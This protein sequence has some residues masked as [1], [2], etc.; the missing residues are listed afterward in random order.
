MDNLIYMFLND[1]DN[2]ILNSIDIF[3]NYIHDEIALLDNVLMNIIIS[4]Y[5]LWFNF[6][7]DS[8]QFFPTEENNNNANGLSSDRIK[9]LPEKV[10]EN[11]NDVCTIC[12][13]NYKTQ[14]LVIILPCNHYYH[15]DCIISWLKINA[16]CAICR[17]KIS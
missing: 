12:R 7:Y 10:I 9:S 8:R 17:K 16:S 1:D 3:N 15:K 4:H 13:N 11:V 5:P 6:I 2:D 14:E